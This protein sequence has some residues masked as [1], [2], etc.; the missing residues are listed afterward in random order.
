MKSADRPGLSMPVSPARP[1]A[2]AGSTVMRPQRGGQ[3]QLLI[4]GQLPGK[5]RVGV[6]AGDHG[7]DTQP[8]GSGAPRPRPIAPGG[9]RTPAWCSSRNGQILRR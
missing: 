5:G 2:L 3:V 9:N 1:I 7:F 4:S 6:S 8:R